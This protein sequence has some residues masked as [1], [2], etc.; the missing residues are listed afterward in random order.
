MSDDKNQQENSW[1]SSSSSSNDSGTTRNTDSG[2]DIPY[3]P[4]TDRTNL[5]ESTEFDT[6]PFIPP[7]T[8]SDD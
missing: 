1:S 5:N 6:K 8:K 7:A 3:V 4:P 2:N